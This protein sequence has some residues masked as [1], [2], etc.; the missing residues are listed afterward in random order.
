MG[1][2]IPSATKDV[3]LRLWLQGHTYREVSAKTGISL[4]ALHGLIAELRRSAP[5]MD[6]IRELCVILN[7]SGSNVYD[8]IRGGQL[9]ERL[10][11]LGVCLDELDNYIKLAEMLSREKREETEEFIKSS[12]KLIKLQL[13]T[14]KTYAEIIRDIEEK[15]KQ[16]VS[17]EAKIK[18][19]TRRIHELTAMKAQ[20]E[21]EMR[22]AEERL[23][24]GRKKCT[25]EREV[26][27]LKLE[28]K[29][30]ISEI[31]S[32]RNELMKFVRLDYALK[33]RRL[34]VP[35]KTCYAVSISIDFAIVENIIKMGSWCSSRC[36]FCGG[37]S[38]YSASEIAW[39]LAQLILP[40]LKTWQ[41]RVG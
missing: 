13:Q 9:I 28:H 35:C 8:A 16:I 4:G 38:T 6:K 36:P 29:R 26:T 23:N 5:D 41:K 12:I 18:D 15:T 3:A 19:A 31:D 27:Y 39:Y 2:R 11:R 37:Y 17:L 25:L 40:A 32:L 1:L 21:K 22:E 7:R 20:I 24:L 30:L 14:G 10:N 34:I 33:T